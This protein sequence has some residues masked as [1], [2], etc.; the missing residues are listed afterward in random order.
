MSLKN[1]IIFKVKGLN[2]ERSF[3]N[4]SKSINVYNLKKEENGISQFEVDYK[5]FKKTKKILNTNG[6]EIIFIKNQGF[7]FKFKSFLSRYGLIFGLIICTIFYILQ[8]SFIFQIKVLGTP[9]EI[10]GEIH[11]FVEKNLNSYF[12]CNIDTKNIENII[13]DEFEQVSSVSVAIVGQTLIINYNPSTL[14]DEMKGDFEP[15][16]SNVNGIITNINLVSGTLNFSVG[17]IIQEGDILV[18]P[19]IIDTDGETR[20]VMAKAQID[21]NVWISESITHY[22]YR[23]QT[24][25]TGNKIVN[26][27]IKIGSLT[28]YS[29]GQDNYFKDYEE[30]CYTKSLTPN[31]LLP[32]KIERTIFYETV[33]KEIIQPFD[34]VRE[35]IIEKARQKTLIFL[36]EN[37]I[38]LNE[39]YTIKDAGDVHKVT[40]TITTSQTIGG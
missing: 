2:Q 6:F 30:E 14:P 38:I 19:Y 13:K 5:N 21:V 18:S 9:N 23:L 36:D 1:R 22:D 12:K 39:N 24:E 37:A 4:I 7:L 20:E 16:V 27:E 28:I 29:Y 8:Y 25:R 34:E 26:N 35:Q 15:L 11:N 40:Y 32:L 10:K 3:N 33:T 17:D 31:F